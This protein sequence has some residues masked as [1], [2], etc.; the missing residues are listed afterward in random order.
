MNPHDAQQHKE[1][2]V[3]IMGLD[4][5]EPDDAQQ[6]RKKEKYTGDTMGLDFREPA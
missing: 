6:H 1:R 2:E 5:R 4:F 3:Y